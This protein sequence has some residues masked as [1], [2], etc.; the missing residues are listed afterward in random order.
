[1]GRKRYLRLPNLPLPEVLIRSGIGVGDQRLPLLDP[2]DLPPCV[3]I[4]ALKHGEK[5][6]TQLH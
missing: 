3:V 4:C 1:M 6:P 2:P 5:L